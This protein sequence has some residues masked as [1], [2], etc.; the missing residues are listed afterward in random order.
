M[1]IATWNVNG[2]RA[3]IEFVQAWLADRQPDVVGRRPV[4]EGE[5]AGQLV[6]LDAGAQEPGADPRVPPLD[7]GGVR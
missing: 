3:R 6:R 4:R 7:D 5:R 2:L 1:K